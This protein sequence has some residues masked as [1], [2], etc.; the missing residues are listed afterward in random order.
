MSDTSD[1]SKPNPMRSQSTLNESRRGFLGKVGLLAGSLSALSSH[2]VLAG[3]TVSRDSVGRET[4]V[5]AKLDKRISSILAQL[6]AEVRAAQG[7]LVLAADG[8]YCDFFVENNDGG[9]FHEKC[10]SDPFLGVILTK[11]VYSSRRM[12]ELNRRSASDDY[13]DFFVEGSGPPWHEKIDD[14]GIRGDLENPAQR[15]FALR[16]SNV[17]QT[18]TRIAQSV[19]QCRE[20]E[21][22]SIG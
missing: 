2:A 9:P 3:E 20:D 16:R 22:I 4:R 12:Q 6:E 14:F 18:F 5:A 7:A 15:S 21:S 10:Q 17:V 1:V 19:A 8:G 13:S 11:E